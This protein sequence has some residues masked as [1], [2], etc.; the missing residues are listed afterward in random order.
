MHRMKRWQRL[1]GLIDSWWSEARV[2]DYVESR[3]DGLCLV[4]SDAP[5]AL[6]LATSS[7]I[8]DGEALLGQARNLRDRRFTLLGAEIPREHGWPWQ[9]DWR[10]NH[11]WPQ[12]Y[13]RHYDFYEKRERPYDVKI[14]WELAR[15]GFLPPLLQAE[16]LD[17]GEWIEPVVAVVEDW[18]RSNPLAHTIGWDPLE[19]S[20]RSVALVCLLEMLL[21]LGE[22]RRRPIAPFLRLISAHGEFVWRTIEDTDVRSNHYVGNIVA[23][24]LDG[25]ALRGAYPSADQWIEYAMRAIPRE[26]TLQLLPDGVD[27]EKSLAYH[28]L[29]TELLLVALL[30]MKRAG[31]S[32]PGEAARRI[33]SACRY[34]ANC[35]RPD[36]LTPNVGDNDSARVLTWDWADPRDHRPLIG[37]A[38]VLFEDGALKAI[39]ARAPLAVPWLLG[40]SG[41]EC[42]QRLRPEPPSPDSAHYDAG[43]VVVVRN[44]DNYLWCD[45]GEVGLAGRGGHGHNDL[46]SFELVLGGAPLVVDPGSP[47]Y[48]ADFDTHNRFRSTAYHNTLRIDGEELAP[49]TG[50]WRIR[51]D[52]IP[53]DVE[54]SRDPDFTTIRATHSGYDRLPDPVHHTRELQFSP[55]RGL[56]LC[57]DELRCHGRHLVERFFRLAPSVTAVTCGSGAQLTTRGRVW[58]LVWDGSST[59]AVEGGWVSPAYGVTEPSSVLVLRDAIDGETSLRWSIG[60]IT[61]A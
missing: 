52:A 25:L 51:N 15:L 12:R 9:R 11:T 18:E 48:S 56:V 58:R 30:A 27:Y 41:L 46:F 42:W 38:A 13:F 22:S 1:E 21:A 24:L 6:R 45:V 29:V 3:R 39:A 14:P 54:V 59:A 17:S 16:A 34:S 10:E 55:T 53:F 60:P 20:L 2:R 26:V 8:A 28:K 7:G 5:S 35:T 4:A 36:G 61:D 57:H 40:T 23:L 47:V 19:A 44:G 50:W 37:V 33:R 49:M 31:F 32:M 43:G